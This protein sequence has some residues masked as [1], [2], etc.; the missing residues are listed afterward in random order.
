MRHPARKRAWWVLTGVVWLGG[1]M[2]GSLAMAR[3]APTRAGHAVS[4]CELEAPR[5]RAP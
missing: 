2:A 4:G 1:V 5:G 3:Y